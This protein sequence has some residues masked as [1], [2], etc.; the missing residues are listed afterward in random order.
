[1]YCDFVVF[2]LKLLITS[3]DSW[4]KTVIFTQICH[5]FVKLFSKKIP[6]KCFRLPL[7]R[8]NVQLHLWNMH[9]DMT[10]VWLNS[11]IL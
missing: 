3:S 2:V 4:N 6:V 5:S 11:Y 1:M 10:F 9:F 8:N 7:I